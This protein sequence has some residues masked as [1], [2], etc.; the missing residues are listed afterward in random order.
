MSNI[1]GRVARLRKTVK[2]AAK[3]K[4]I[5][6]QDE[7]EPGL[8]HDS[9]RDLRLTASELAALEVSHDVTI[10]TIVRETPANN[11]DIE[12]KERA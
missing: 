7:A 8:Y 10:I 3:P 2:P 6:V 11:P 4:L 1:T 5:L 12:R 9:G